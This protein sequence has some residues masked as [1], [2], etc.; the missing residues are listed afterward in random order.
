[1]FDIK[2]RSKHN[3]AY[4]GDARLKALLQQWHGIDPRSDFESCVWRRIR[5]ASAEEVIAPGLWV[6]LR[7]WLAA[8]P[9][10][11]PAMAA[12]AG[13]LFGV[14]L[15]LSAP[16]THPGP[17]STASLLHAQTLAGGYLTMVSGG[18]R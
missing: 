18:A 3:V 1:M 8:E 15:A 9:A 17:Y 12:T 11:V 7:G 2:L 16:H 10:W 5:V 4:P 14:S 6:I 13:L